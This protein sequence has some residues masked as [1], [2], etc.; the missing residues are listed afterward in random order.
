LRISGI[1]SGVLALVFLVWIH[2]VLGRN[3]STTLFIKKD[4]RLVTRGPYRL[5]RHPMYS[6]YFLL[7][8]SSFLISE[9]WLVGLSGMAVIAVL[10]TV[11]LGIEE[12]LL[13][14]R[15][16]DDY[17]RYMLHT[18]KFLPGFNRKARLR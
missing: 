6:A 11:R 17:R 7:F 14:R 12:A 18:P 9:S 1:F 13:M 8:F 4:H 2:V 15:F 5:M 10:M 3:F 16:G